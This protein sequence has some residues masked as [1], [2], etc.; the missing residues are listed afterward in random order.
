MQKI[1]TGTGPCQKLR[2]SVLYKSKI[3]V[4]NSAGVINYQLIVINKVGP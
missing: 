1:L 2:Y 4:D 3:S